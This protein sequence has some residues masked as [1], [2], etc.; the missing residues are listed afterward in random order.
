[1]LWG[2]ESKPSPSLSLFYL[3][4]KGV[5][6]GLGGRVSDWRGWEWLFET[7]KCYSAIWL[8]HRNV[9]VKK[10]DHQVVTNDWTINWFPVT[11]TGL[12][13]RSLFFFLLCL[14]SCEILIPWPRIGSGHLVVQVLS[15]NHWTTRG[16]PRKPSCSSPQIGWEHVACFQDYSWPCSCPFWSISFSSRKKD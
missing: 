6:A 14:K 3:N 7:L 12:W 4:S 11:G 13:H 10:A 5:G 2:V 15:L 1:M 8:F 9:L 16:V